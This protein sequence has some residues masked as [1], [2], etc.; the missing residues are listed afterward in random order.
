[1]MADGCR[2]LMTLLVRDE[3]DIIQN[4]IEYHRK[5]GV[6]DFIVT[7]NGS[8]DG[9][10][11]YLK[12]LEDDGVITLI[13]EPEHIHAQGKWVTRMAKMA[14][15]DPTVDWIIHADADEFFWC[16]EN[17]DGE[18]DLASAFGEVYSSFGKVLIPRADMLIDPETDESLDFL[19]RNTLEDMVSLKRLGPKVSHRP[20]RDIT[21]SEGNH[22]IRGVEYKD[23]KID[24]LMAFHFPIRSLDQFRKKVV[25][26]A[27]AVAANPNLSPDIAKH[28]RIAYQAHLD[29]RLKD[30]FSRF[31]LT[32]ETKKQ[33]LD[34]GDLAINTSI[35]DVMKSK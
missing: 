30:H 21:V 35:L 3:I 15:M 34:N 26:G 27:T 8:V 16:P 14:A 2:I 7:D 13:S 23:T 4:N 33:R 19:N 12:G 1:M 25:G 9:T 18:V 29:G 28:W 10:Y 17:D 22:V 24:G 5:V 32:A 11:E 31:L 6:T 20:H